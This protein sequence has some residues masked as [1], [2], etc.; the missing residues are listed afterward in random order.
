MLINPKKENTLLSFVIASIVNEWIRQFLRMLN[1]QK[2]RSTSII[3]HSEL[4][5]T[6]E[7]IEYVTVQLTYFIS[8][9]S[10]IDWF[11]KKKIYLL[12]YI[13]PTC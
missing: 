9:S 8:N 5:I 4:F 7:M 11:Y 3:G 10:F 6:C 1:V 12:F 2:K 13:V